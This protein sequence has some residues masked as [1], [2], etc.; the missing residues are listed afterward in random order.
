MFNRPDWSQMC[1][2]T[3]IVQVPCGS[4]NALAASTGLW[5]SVAAAHAVVKGSTSPLDI[6]SVIHPQQ[7]HHHDRCS[8]G[9]KAHSS[10]NGNI[11][12]NSHSHKNN[13]NNIYTN[14]NEEKRLY[15]FLSVTYGMI[16]CLDLGTEH[17]RWMGGA[18]FT[19]GAL[20]QIMR[21]KSYGLQVAFVAA[22]SNDYNG[23]S[24]SSSS[25]GNGGGN[26]TSSKSTS[27]AKAA[28]TTSTGNGPPLK[29]A[30][31]F[32][33]MEKNLT[34]LPQHHNWQ[35]MPETSIQLLALC[36]LPWLDTNFN[37]AP[38][39][40]L[41]NGQLHLVY[42]EVKSRIQSLKILTAVESGGHMKYMKE[43]R[44]MALAI[45]PLAPRGETYV[46]VDGE[47]AEYGLTFVEV[48]GSLCNT[49]IAP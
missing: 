37:L 17:M 15:S 1:K 44:V 13:K 32:K 22:G 28:T 16:P 30:S 26:G 47:E 48:H 43:R 41:N 39:A 49:F 12:N 11:T 19:V 8:E 6:A 35:W 46:V 23:S 27:P 45:R 9:K 24:S 40:R 25:S 38:A 42:S 31:D 14:M 34:N 36:N 10:S 2:D 5:N 33:K 7:H 21:K 4:G 29:Y 3:A 20:Q 18:R